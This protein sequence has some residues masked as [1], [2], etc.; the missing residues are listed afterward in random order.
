ML[1]LASLRVHNPR[2]QCFEYAQAVTER[3]L[4]VSGFRAELRASKHQPG[5]FTLEVDGTPQSQVDTDDLT[6]LSFE[7]VRRIGHV[8]D[9][10]APARSPLTA[11][12]LG[13]GAL[14]LPR[15]I[16]ATRPSSRQQVIELEAELIELVRTELP[17]PKQAHVR[18]RIGDARAVA[19]KLPAGFVH[20]A[21]VI[22]VDIF[23]GARTPAHVTSAE[24]YGELTRWLAPAGVVAVNIADGHGLAFAKRQL[25]TIASVWPHV[26]FAADTSLLKGRRF[27]NLVAY[28]SDRPLPLDPLARALNSDPFPA[29]L[30][31][32]DE[33]ERFISGASVVHDADAVASPLP[34]RSVFIAR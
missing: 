11:L 13:G 16:D 27:G 32:G 5:L 29:K 17:L 26:A 20:A 28:A 19:A 23:S 33:L 22:V 7:Y 21:E 12:H 6:H 25:A 4:T 24:F 1:D 9:L 31:H 8:I 14:T 2:F 15:Y 30:V 10:V 18:I 3:V 34:A